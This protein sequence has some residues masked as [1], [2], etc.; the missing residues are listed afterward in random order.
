METE[1]ERR[2]QCLV[3]FSVIIEKRNTNSRFGLYGTVP[4]VFLMHSGRC[5]GLPA[6]R[7]V[8]PYQ[9]RTLQ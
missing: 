8:A 7:C 4:E 2:R 9:R 1:R 6:R 5:P 3:A